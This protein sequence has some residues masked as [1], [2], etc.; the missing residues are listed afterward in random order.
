MNGTVSCIVLFFLRGLSAAFPEF[1]I[2]VTLVEE[3]TCEAE[4]ACR[5]DRHDEELDMAM[6]EEAVLEEQNKIEMVTLRMELEQQQQTNC[7]RPKHKQGDVKSEFNRVSTIFQAQA[8]TAR[9]AG[10]FI[11][12][13]ASFLLMCARQGY[14]KTKPNR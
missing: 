13:G 5:G 7:N 14:T 6:A 8:A 11:A 12:L 2:G 4:Q 3:V 9:N 10:S 1:Q